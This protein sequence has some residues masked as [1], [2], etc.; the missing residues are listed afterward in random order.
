MREVVTMQKLVDAGDAS[1]V[2]I[3]KSVRCHYDCKIE[4]DV[5]TGVE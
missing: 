5:L 3:L 2:A 4:L 1:N